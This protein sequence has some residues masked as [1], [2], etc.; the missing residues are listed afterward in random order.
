MR[1]VTTRLNLSWTE[2]YTPRLRAADQARWLLECVR[3]KVPREDSCRRG[4]RVDSA[5]HPDAMLVQQIFDWSGS[6]MSK[7]FLIGV[8][9][10]RKKMCHASLA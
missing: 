6:D 9:A 4:A 8:G 2:L 1:P 5:D 7:F 10:E 3:S